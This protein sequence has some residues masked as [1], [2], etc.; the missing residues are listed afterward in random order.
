VDGV[1]VGIGAPELVG[2]HDRERHLI[3]LQ[4]APHRRA[5]D[6]RVLRERAIGLLLDPKQEIEPRL[7]PARSEAA[8]SAVAIW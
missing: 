5:V 6:A 2:Q 4:T 7:A 8:I 3:E 1:D